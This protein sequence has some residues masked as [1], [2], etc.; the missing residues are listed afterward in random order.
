VS[1]SRSRVW[2]GR[3]RPQS[4]IG[5]V[6]DARFVAFILQGR[7]DKVIKANRKTLATTSS[8]SSTA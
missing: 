8:G 2:K 4:G 7:V 6:P 3:Q 5:L 1:W